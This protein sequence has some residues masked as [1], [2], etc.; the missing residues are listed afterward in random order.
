[1]P[2]L[3]LERLEFA[4]YLT[5]TPKP[6]DSAGRIARDFTI[7]MKDGKATGTP[8]V[9]IP[10]QI[11]DQLRSGWSSLPQFEPYLNPSTV[12]VPVPR[13]AIGGKGD[14]W[15]PD[16]I[17]HELVRVGLGQ[18]VAPLLVRSETIRKAARSVSS[19]RPRAMD[20]FRTMA[21]QRDLATIGSVT[22]V[23]DVV[24]TGATML[25]SANRLTEE[26]PGIPIR[27][28]AVVRTQS[29]PF[30]FHRWVDPTVGAIVLQ[31][32]GWCIRRP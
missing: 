11:A 31:E 5:Y 10:V 19:E 25:G 24:T 1:M 9:P 12:L 2:P 6:R 23:D 17:A 7:T 30:D 16:Q 3:R 27:A 20:H 15:V 32:N 13:S 4:S 21:V 26:Y 29:D 8:P 28:F 14:L 22:L 18:R